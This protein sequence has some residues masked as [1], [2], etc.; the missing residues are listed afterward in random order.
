MNLFTDARVHPLD[1]MVSATLRFIPFMMLG[2]EIPVIVAWA[3]FETIYPKFYHANVR[4]NFGPLR[5]ILVTPQSHRIHHACE[6]RY[7]DRNFGFTFSIWDRMFGTQYTDDFDYPD[8]GVTDPDY[9]REKLADPRSL[10]VTFGR[11]LI[12]PFQQIFQRR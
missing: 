11:Q 6:D 1:R 8:T 4:L 10:L 5:Y 2:N 3:V 7:R 12:Y 9:P